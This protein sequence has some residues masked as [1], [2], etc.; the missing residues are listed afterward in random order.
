MEI[1][2]FLVPILY[3][4]IHFIEYS[5]YLARISGWV[6]GYKLLGYS[7]Q[8]MFF[9]VTRFS[10][11]ALM[12]I[13]GLIVDN[14][15]SKQTFIRVIQCSLL[16]ASFSYLLVFIFR[17]K[18]TNAISAIIV[19]KQGMDKIVDP[20]YLRIILIDILK[21]RKYIFYSIIVFTC[22]SLGVFIAFYFAIIYYDYRATISQLSGIV[23]GLATILLTFVIEPKLSSYFDKNDPESISILYAILLGRM[24]AVFFVSQIMVILLGLF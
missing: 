7:I 6:T 3:G 8:Q 21:Y 22:Y 1:L 5:S 15:V 13:L 23:N 11:V 2:I 10:F 16:L 14:N 20:Y 18:I 17:N 19:K 9:V 24:I 12:P 4:I